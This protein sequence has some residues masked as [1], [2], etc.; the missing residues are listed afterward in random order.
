MLV[1]RALSYV[2]H[3]TGYILETECSGI[4]NMLFLGKPQ[5]TGVSFIIKEAMDDEGRLPIWKVVHIKKR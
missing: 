1:M 3:N 4:A 2:V 5:R